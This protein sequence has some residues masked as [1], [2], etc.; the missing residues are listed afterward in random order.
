MPIT[1]RDKDLK[2]LR[3]V[4]ARF[5]R[6]QDVR[7]FGSRAI[8]AARRTSDIDLAI[9]A[10]RMTA[11]EWAELR[12]A[13][14]EAPIVYKIDVVRLDTLQD[15]KLKHKIMKEGIVLDTKAER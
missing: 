7:V 2:T 6:M 8:G 15:E 5:P 12:E 9:T 11:T 14:D 13:I 1:L 3:A 10:P 4:F